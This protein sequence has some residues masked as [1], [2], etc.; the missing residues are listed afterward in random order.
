M[1]LVLLGEDSRDFAVSLCLDTQQEE[2]HQN[3]IMQASNLQDGEKRNF[4]CLNQFCWYFFMAAPA[5]Y[6]TCIYTY[7]FLDTVLG[8]HNE[9]EQGC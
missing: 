4:Y 3:P 6:H 5:D 9:R 7:S 8:V 1:R 2:P